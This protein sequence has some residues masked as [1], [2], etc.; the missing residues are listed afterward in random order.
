MI[1]GLRLAI[2]LLTI[3]PVRA[4][5][6]IDRRRAGW[7]MTWAP[8][9]GLA[10][11]FVTASTVFGLRLLFGSDEID[12]IPPLCGIALLAVMTG[13]LHLDGLADL[14]DGFGARRDRDGT[15]AVMREPGVGA[16]A[17]VAL[18]LVLALQA[19][20]LGLAIVRHHGTVAI[21]V[22]LLTSR[23]A[24]TLACASRVAPARPGG[25]GALVLGSV[26]RARAALVLV[27][28]LIAATLAGRFDYHGGGL[29][30]SAH[31]AVGLL[32][33]LAA[34]FGVRWLAVRKLGGVNGDVL[35]AMVE[36]ATTVT[37]L[38]MAL[39]LPT[40]LR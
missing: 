30:E 1:G 7:A 14:V 36:T 22:S 26:P 9:V 17:V 31:A 5:D 2:G 37:L 20:A 3:L 6:E 40:W 21:L 25:L 28:A 27:L 29:P 32:V 13:G 18:V 38:V 33:G 12:L 11:G 19:S 35:G 10:L 23:T 34:A 24:V 16:F 15:L 8:A 39:S 4:P